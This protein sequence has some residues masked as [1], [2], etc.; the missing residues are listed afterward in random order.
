MTHHQPAVPAPALLDQAE[1]LHRQRPQGTDQRPIC[2]QQQSVDLDPTGPDVTL[3]CHLPAR[4]H[5][6][7]HYDTTRH[8][9]W[10]HVTGDPTDT[11]PPAA[12][13]APDEPWH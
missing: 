5:S 6:V 12:P 3:T 1:A 10:T 13:G 7:E 11:Q 9:V 4:H 2:D 8:L